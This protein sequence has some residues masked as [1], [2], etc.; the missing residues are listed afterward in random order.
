[1]MIPIIFGWISVHRNVQ[2]GMGG[3]KPLIGIH[4]IKAN[5][6]NCNTISKRILLIYGWSK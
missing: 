6:Q 4:W 2:V 3:Y 1:M 5:W